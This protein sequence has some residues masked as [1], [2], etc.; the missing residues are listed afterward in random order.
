MIKHDKSDL[1]L[2]S[3]FSIADTHHRPNI[4]PCLPLL[5]QKQVTEDD[6]GNESV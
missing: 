6:P 2:G 4:H 1:S 3:E 5:K